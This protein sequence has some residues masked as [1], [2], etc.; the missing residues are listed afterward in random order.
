MVAVAKEIERLARDAASLSLTK[1]KREVGNLTK[2]YKLMKQGASDVEVDLAALN[3][4]RHLDYDEN[5]ILT[6][7]CAMI[8]QRLRVMP[9]VSLSDHF[10]ELA[11][12]MAF[13]RQAWIEE[14]G[15]LPEV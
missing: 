10:G 14:I 8:F 9:G 6:K 12:E 3:S 13:I 1:V 2:S 5:N 4:Q 11:N 15:I 7:I